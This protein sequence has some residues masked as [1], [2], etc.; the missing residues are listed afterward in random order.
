M[1]STASLTT[2]MLT[3][4]YRRLLI[5]PDTSDISFDNGLTNVVWA[6]GTKSGNDLTFHSARGKG[7]AVFTTDPCQAGTTYNIPWSHTIDASVAGSLTVEVGDSV[8]WLTPN[9]AF[10]LFTSTNCDGSFLHLACPETNTDLDNKTEN[11]AYRQGEI[12]D[13]DG[14]QPINNFIAQSFTQTFYVPGEYPYG[15]LFSNRADAK[16]FGIITVASDGTTDAG[17]VK[18]HL[19]GPSVEQC[20][21]CCAVESLPAING[22]CLPALTDTAAN[23]F[24]TTEKFTGSLRYAVPPIT[25]PGFYE[26]EM[27]YDTCKA[28]SAYL[29]GVIGDSATVEC[30]TGFTGESKTA[31][32]DTSGTWANLPDCELIV[33]PV[34]V[35][36]LSGSQSCKSE[37]GCGGAQCD[38]GDNTTELDKCVEGTTQCT[39]IKN[40]HCVDRRMDNGAIFVDSDEDTCAAY[41]GKRDPDTVYCFGDAAADISSYKGCDESL[42]VTEIK[43]GISYFGF[44]RGNLNLP[45]E[46]AGAGIEIEDSLTASEAC[47]RCDT[48]AVN[49]IAYEE[50]GGDSEC[51]TFPIAGGEFIILDRTMVTC[52]T[53]TF[54]GQAMPGLRSER[55]AIEVALEAFVYSNS[56]LVDSITKKNGD[57]CKQSGREACISASPGGSD[58]SDVQYV[59]LSPTT[60]GFVARVVLASG[61][62]KENI[63]AE[64]TLAT[65]SKVANWLSSKAGAFTV[66]SFT[67]LNPPIAE[68]VHRTSVPRAASVATGTT[69]DDAIGIVPRFKGN[70]ALTSGNFTQITNNEHVS[71]FVP[72]L[73]GGDITVAVGRNE[74]TVSYSEVDASPV[75]FEAGVIADV[76]EGKK[77]IYHDGAILQVATRVI[78]EH[79]NVPTGT[80][81]S[82]T[83]Q[84]TR[85]DI[86][87]DS[88]SSTC[89]ASSNGPPTNAGICIV[90]VN[91]PAQWFTGIVE[92]E[93]NVIS[94]FTDSG[95]DSSTT[96]ELGVVTIIG[97]IQGNSFNNIVAELPSRPI[98]PSESFNVPIF[99]NFQYQLQTFTI[100]FAADTGVTINSFVINPAGGW[101]G[102]PANA[103][104]KA[105][106]AFIRDPTP[107]LPA[108]VRT[109]LD[110]GN[111]ELL[112]TMQVSVGS[113]TAPRE[114]GITVKWNFTSDILD[115]TVEPSDISVI[116]NREGESKTG[117]AN[118]YVE[119]DSLKD[120][121][122]KVDRG[123]VVNTARLGAGGFSVSIYPIGIFATGRTAVVPGNQLLCIKVGRNREFTVGDLCSEILFDGSETSGGDVDIT[124]IHFSEGITRSQIVRVLYPDLPLTV[125]ATPS[126]M[127]RVKGWTDRSN[128]D[129]S[130]QFQPSRLSYY[131]RMSNDGSNPAFLVDVTNQVPT[132]A[133]VLSNSSVAELSSSGRHELK[134]LMD[135]VVE[136]TVTGPGDVELGS[137]L[138]VVDGTVPGASVIGLD[139]AVITDLTLSLESIASPFEATGVSMQV[140]HRSLIQEG[141]TA[142]ISAFAILDDGIR[143][144]LNPSDGLSVVSTANDSISV[145]T[146]GDD[147]E[148]EVPFMAVSDSGYLVKATWESSK[149]AGCP[150]LL[151]ATG[152]ANLTVNIPKAFGVRIEINGF[153]ESTVPPMIVPLGDG[154]AAA[155]LP[156]QGS[157]KVI[158]LY[159]SD[160]GDVEVDVTADPRTVYTINNSLITVTSSGIVA[161]SSQTGSS[162]IVVS[163]LHEDVTDSLDIQVA[164]FD[165]LSVTATPSPEYP[166]SDHVKVS[167]LS[168][169]HGT[170]PTMYQQANFNLM[171]HLSN[172]KDLQIL[173][174]GESFS[175][176]DDPSFAIMSGAVLSA[177]STGLAIVQGSF[178]GKTSVGY[179]I[180]ISDTAV[181]VQSIDTFHVVKTTSSQTLST[182]SGLPG[183][184]SGYVRLKFTLSDGRI[185]LRSMKDG[186]NGA[187]YPGLFTFSSETTSAATI[188][189]ETG[190]VMLQ[191]NYHKPV[192][193]IASAPGNDGTTVTDEITVFCNLSPKVGDVDLGSEFGVSLPSKNIN[194]TFTVTLRV[195]TGTSAFLGAFDLYVTFDPDILTITDPKSDVTFN[196]ETSS[197]SSGIL[198]A[199]VDGGELHFSGSI[200]EQKLN[201]IVSL[202]DIRF[203]AVGGGQS[204]VSGSIGLLADTSLPPT[205][206]G[207]RNSPFV[208]GNLIQEVQ[209][210]RR[211]HRSALPFRVSKRRNKARYRRATF[212]GCVQE[213]GD[214]NSDCTFDVNDVRFV[215]QYLAYRGIDFGGTDGPYVKNTVEHPDY[216]PALLD[217]DHN[218]NVNGKDASFLNKVNLGILVFV[219]DVR[220]DS[221]GIGNTGDGCLVQV[222]AKLYGKG[223]TAVNSSNTRLF[224]A[225]AHPASTFV[226]KLTTSLEAVVTG[227][228]VAGQLIKATLDSSDLEGYTFLARFGASF[229]EA[230]QD[231]GVSIAQ[232][233]L[234]P[235]GKVSVKF[236]SGSDTGPFAYTTKLLLNVTDKS[237]AGESATIKSSGNSGYN[238]LVTFSNAQD[239]LACFTAM[240]PCGT[241]IESAPATLTSEATCVTDLCTGISCDNP[242]SQCHNDIGTCFSGTCTYDFKLLG[243]ECN[244]GGQCDGSGSCQVS[245]LTIT[246]I[247]PFSGH[248][249]LKKLL[250]SFSLWET[251]APC[252]AFV[253]SR[254]T[255]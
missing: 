166:G 60:S 219:E 5:S 33:L 224:I 81:R 240:D 67:A 135:G 148:I 147:V 180:N 163:F 93:L 28:E 55:A 53:F 216:R 95:P 50:T 160:P 124:A 2:K 77:R 66:S 63:G 61:L 102:T 233:I 191:S 45:F 119:S 242:P 192:T 206:I 127:R 24:V 42:A 59:V 156:T 178:A 101:S 222:S 235:S 213:Y 10:Y 251:Y 71:S 47:C 187:I 237:W 12:V 181:F 41:V 232:A 73:Y 172:R 7:E 87:T 228:A 57:P 150:D 16:G 34:C 241:G 4:T 155:G 13:E 179:E 143:L 249:D 114:Y 225:L 107:L 108:I 115:N 151:I 69:F 248:A 133:V 226:P 188:V 194:D 64:L 128:S 36:A 168:K 197:L 204:E 190:A 112:A 65:A 125:V 199:I 9:D 85:L 239:S 122:L 118:V 76:S 189:S 21:K 8:T 100:D 153:D 94:Y 11:C 86:T 126:T 196:S 103:G 84:A 244:D 169:I 162:T 227:E 218:G 238:P 31:T 83:V 104:N 215:T 200:D 38:D 217:A 246:V 205:D 142:S 195:N 185:Y 149:I 22:T 92:G 96:V 182:L 144:E 62:A 46:E 117:S 183:E 30:P 3:C 68:Y 37:S 154:A 208:A 223:N 35:T 201:G 106:L 131:A 229:D 140:E 164:K 247:R 167:T 132:S 29:S 207:I 56:G 186:G 214:T 203:K 137:T 32:C 253:S 145:A 19:S 161:A 99:A 234:Q 26:L 158:L 170:S 78:D 221:V 54:P 98:Y 72:G 184:L 202:I 44:I 120:M 70:E 14:S 110:P 123:T 113:A 1:S 23:S 121:F 49:Q 250:H 109:S 134:G 210:F 82:I 130:F 91:L 139:V 152:H 43:T 51:L 245:N 25:S 174:Q 39:G 48:I 141:E 80:A 111:G 212:P 220:I 138:I 75:K 18:C 177:F 136:V 157:L 20:S 165:R 146:T 27:A 116:Y 176:I 254:P 97:N 230:F 90:R 105:T 209:S 6:I 159:P 52:L 231:V 255:I 74:K 15:D 236:M 252:N 171:M 243:I 88:V 58:V 173:S 193:F 40:S 79:G 175:I 89:T 129:C 17:L 198:D 211:S